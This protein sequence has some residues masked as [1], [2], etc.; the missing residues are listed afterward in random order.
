MSTKELAT[1]IYNHINGLRK[2]GIDWDEWYDNREIEYI[3]NMIENYH[4]LERL[5]PD[6]AEFQGNNQTDGLS[7]FRG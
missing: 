1:K 7:G 4:R 3:K 6:N 2:D 5:D